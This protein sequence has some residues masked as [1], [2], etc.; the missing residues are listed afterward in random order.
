MNNRIKA[1]LI[2]AVAV[3]CWASCKKNGDAPVA[4]T[5][6]SIDL[7]NTSNNTINFFV[8][9][10]RINNT[11]PY[12]PGGTLGYYFVAAGTQNYSAKV[13]GTGVTLFDKSFNF[14]AD[15]V[16]SLYVSGTTANDI[17]KST[18]VLVADTGTNAATFAK[19]RFVSASSNGGNLSAVLT[20]TLK[21]TVSFN[22]NP[23]KNSTGFLRVHGGPNT[24]N[25][26]RAA[27]P[28]APLKVTVTLTA[29]RIYTLYGYGTT[30]TTNN[31]GLSAGL[32]INY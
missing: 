2:I 1:F 19:V 18:D 11:S 23:Y 22:D 5:K 32:T 26:Y 29:G 10:T 20:D 25:I 7:I 24:V 15:S 3:T 21:K 4:V 14:S 16:Y 13:D 8:N 27:Y 17:F 28:D 30:A 6:T 12:Y 9:G 31:S